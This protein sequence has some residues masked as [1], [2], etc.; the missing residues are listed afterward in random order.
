MAVQWLTITE[1][2]LKVADFTESFVDDNFVLIAKYQFE[3]LPYINFEVFTAISGYCWALLLGLTLITGAMIYWTEK[4]IFLHSNSNT[5]VQISLYT[6]GLL[7]QRDVGGRVP[8]NLG[9]RV[10][11]IALAITLMVI[12]NTY[13]AM[14]TTRNIQSTKTLPIQGFTDPKISNPTPSFK[15]GT[16]KGSIGDLFEK[17]NISMWRRLNEFMEPY[18]FTNFKD[19]RERIMKGELHAA[20]V[21]EGDLQTRWKSNLDCDLGIVQN[22]RQQSL[23]FALPKE[24]HWKEPIDYKIRMYKENSFLENMK[25]RY[26]ATKCPT[27]KTELPPQFSMLYL[28]GACILLLLGT[29]TGILIFILEH[30]LNRNIR[31]YAT[32]KRSSYTSNREDQ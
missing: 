6:I 22:I 32:E 16:Y 28:S 12:V 18:K 15:I 14:L 25:N 2:R 19:G 31:R 21:E 1:K 26:L 29:I 8:N 27:K 5:A 10:I 30:I 4:L 24:S 7:F 17:G 13:T 11:S 20:I 9:S 3:P 23:A